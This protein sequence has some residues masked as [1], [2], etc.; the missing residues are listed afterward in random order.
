MIWP[1]LFIEFMTSRSEVIAR[2]DKKE[3]IVARK[4][5]LLNERAYSARSVIEGSTWAARQAG[6]QQCDRRNGCE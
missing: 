5:R 4:G 1:R 6:N 3:R 2:D